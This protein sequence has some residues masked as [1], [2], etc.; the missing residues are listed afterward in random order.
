M[1]ALVSLIA[2][3]AIAVGVS[4]S[5]QRKPQAPPRGDLVELDVV[6]LDREGRPVTDLRQQEFQIKEDGRAREVTTF[7]H[8]TALGSGKPDDA[9]SV[10]LLM[11]DIGVPMTG[12][13]PM[14]QLAQIMLS[15][16]GDGDRVSVVRLASRTDEAVG[17]FATARNRIGDYRGGIVPLSSRD[18]PD[19]VLRMIAKISRQLEPIAHHKK[20][21]LC[22][23][24]RVVC[25][26]E[27]PTLG[28][29]SVF[30]P[31]WVE[32]VSATARAN[33]SVYGVDPTGLSAGS[34]SRRIDGLTEL[35]GGSLFANS[36]DFVR[37]AN[38]I[39]REA[40]HYYLL[41]YPPS[42]DRREVHSIDVKVTRKDVRVRAR[43]RRAD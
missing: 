40:G 38:A 23:G 27:E 16:T 29:N 31:A 39:W 33:V 34:G 7:T 43:K 32:A 18:T 30:W 21:I 20:V 17:D 26:V 36:N 4:A 13:S 5:A 2:G 11:D 28:A 24:L 6:V 14:R 10:V 37:A 9:R 12:T 25:D 35:T 1:R 42:T 22:L 3:A 19:T 41:G 8:V 15:P